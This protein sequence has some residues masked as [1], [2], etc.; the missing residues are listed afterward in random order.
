MPPS[1]SPSLVVFPT[2]LAPADFVIEGSA[3]RG[4][5]TI[6]DLL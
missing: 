5:A 3:A 1:R 6:R 2:A 4:W